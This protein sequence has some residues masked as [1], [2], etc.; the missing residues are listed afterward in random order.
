MSS[1]HCK[2]TTFHNIICITFSLLFCPSQNLI[3]KKVTILTIMY[4][5]HTFEISKYQFLQVQFQWHPSTH[6]VQQHIMKIMFNMQQQPQ[7]PSMEHQQG[8]NDSMFNHYICIDKRYCPYRCSKLYYASNKDLCQDHPQVRMVP[9]MLLYVLN[10]PVHAL[11]GLC[12]HTFYHKLAGR[13]AINPHPQIFKGFNNC[14]IISPYL[15]NIRNFAS[16]L[17]KNHNLSFLLTNNQVFSFTEICKLFK[18]L[19]KCSQIRCQYY[20]IISKQ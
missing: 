3:Q 4:F 5:I 8:F 7:H 6:N 16:T 15:Y 13:F 20:C 1:L 9:A 18:Q 19:V 10:Q 2:A 11:L 12:Y 17:V 14:Q